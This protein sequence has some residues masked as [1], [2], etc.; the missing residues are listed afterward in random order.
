MICFISSGVF[1]INSAIL[2]IAFNATLINF[3]VALAAS[4]VNNERYFNK[5]VSVAFVISSSNMIAGR[6]AA[7][8][9]ENR[10]PAIRSC[11]MMPFADL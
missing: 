9:M 8:F 4:D 10:G 11:G 3:P 1:F 5:Y 6:S 7:L 2:S